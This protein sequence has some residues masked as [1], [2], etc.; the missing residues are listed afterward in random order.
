M[1]LFLKGTRCL[2]DKCAFERR[3]YIPGQHGQKKTRRRVSEYSRQLRE[4]Q[5]LKRIY[6]LLER[7]F[8]FTF[9]KAERLKGMTGDNLVSLLE[10]RLDNVTYRLGLATSR[11]AGRQLVNH[12]HIMVNG[13]KVD[14][15]S[16]FV[17]K[18]DVIEVRPRSRENVAIKASVETVESRGIPSW[19][20]WDHTHLKGEVRGLPT[21]EDAAIPV[22]EQLVVVLYSR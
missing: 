7:Q 22:D 3:N 1:K 17:Q 12:G 21:K 20:E 4:K 5:K 18:D 10:R 14:I 13:K 6:G 15:P 16:F 2:T 11:K 9:G 8:V 19:L